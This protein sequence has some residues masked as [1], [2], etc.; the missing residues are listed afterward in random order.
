M[1][2]FFSVPVRRSHNLKKEGFCLVYLT[3]LLFLVLCEE[4]GWL[5]VIL[6][7][8][9]RFNLICCLLR[10]RLD[11][12]F[13]ACSLIYCQFWLH[14]TSLHLNISMC[15]VYLNSAHILPCQ[16]NSDS[17][18]IPTYIQHVQII[19]YTKNSNQ[20]VCINLI[21]ISSMICIQNIQSQ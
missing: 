19:I 16:Y 6:V 12:L 13:Y 11:L 8:V 10:K 15:A 20:F 14:F 7:N 3:Q 18:K 4:T 5:K 17:S 2:L 1:H 9:Y 21:K